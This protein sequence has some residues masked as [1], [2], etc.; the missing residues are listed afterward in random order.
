M[1]TLCVNGC[2]VKE[3][4][5]KNRL[6]RGIE[7]FNAGRYPEAAVFL[8]QCVKLGGGQAAGL[9]LDHIRHFLARGPLDTAASDVALIKQGRYPEAWLATE[10][11]FRQDPSAAFRRLRNLW[12][13]S[14][15]KDLENA[16]PSPWTHF[17]RSSQAWSFLDNDKALAELRRASAGSKE[18]AWMR[19]F[20]AEILLRRERRYLLADR[21]IS[22]VIASCPWLWEARCLGAE[23]GLTL[24]KRGRLAALDQVDVTGDGRAPF[25][26]WRGVLKL[27]SGAYQ[28]SLE[29]LTQAEALGSHDSLCWGGA[30]L[31]MLGRLEEALSK[32][33]TLLRRDPADQEALVFRAE[34]LRRLGRTRESLTDLDG[35]LERVPDHPWAL[36]NR[37]LCALALEDEA[38]ARRDYLRLVYGPKH[39]VS[40]VKRSTMK[41]VLGK[42]LAQAGGCRR[43]DTHVNLGWMRAAG[44]RVP[45]RPEQA[46]GPWFKALGAA[47]T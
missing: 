1:S 24:G 30:A 17:F 8:R 14:A 37:A 26:A 31:A 5:F 44:L 2:P 15:F 45:S 19:Y 16:P 7:L 29:D 3:E 28:E 47:K 22:G 9:Y 25:L 34:V 20:I 11:A 40:A 21:E 10:Q 43:S 32:L 4:R 39:G 36:V 23:I 41:S 38:S 12:L 27:W 18:R 13:N 33:S 6:Q 42:T 46:L 35:L